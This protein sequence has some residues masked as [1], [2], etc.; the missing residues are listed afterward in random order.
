MVLVKKFNHPRWL[1][2]PL[3]QAMLRRMRSIK[4]TWV[5]EGYGRR[6]FVANVTKAD[7]GLA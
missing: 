6:T 2:R 3:L 4:S 7:Q 1:A 5:G